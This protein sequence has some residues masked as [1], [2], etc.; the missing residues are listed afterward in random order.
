MNKVT[1]V[2]A[3]TQPVKSLDEL[4]ER[5]QAEEP[6][7]RKMVEGIA[8]ISGAMAKF[9]PEINGS[10]LKTRESSERKLKDELGGDF[11]KIRDVLRGTVVGDSVEKTRDA[12]ATFIAKQGDNVLRVKDRI[13]DKGP[14]GYR[15]ILVNFRTPGGLVAELQFNSKA[16]VEAKENA[17]HKLYN[18]M[19]TGNLA[20]KSFDELQAAARA[21]Y[22]K[23]YQDDGDGHWEMKA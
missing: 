11:T 2:A 8:E 6:A 17:G 23:A 20:G 18:S 10:V 19:R 4:Y 22:E 21:I 15:D 5:A 14:S 7:F 1:E 12:A 9:G 13:V 16:M 3:S